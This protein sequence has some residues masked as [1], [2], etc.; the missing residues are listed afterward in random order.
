M[1]KLAASSP[2]KAKVA[3]TTSTLV[4][5]TSSGIFIK[6]E[7]DINKSL[8]AALLDAEAAT[9]A[10]ADRQRY[11]AKPLPA[12]AF[13]QAAFKTCVDRKSAVAKGL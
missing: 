9:E 12:T 7:D 1:V 3:D 4:K 6:S 2:D 10:F 8:G 11:I 13:W 5:V